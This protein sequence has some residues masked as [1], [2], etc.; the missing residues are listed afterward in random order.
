MKHIVIISGGSIEREFA[1]SFCR[2]YEFYKIIGVDGG[3][4]FL[5]ENGIRPTNIVGDFDT[6]EPDILQY[7]KEETG[8]PIRK[9]NPEKDATDT[10]IALR[11]A[12]SM[13][14]EK[15]TILGAF[16]TR[17][18]H[19]LGNMQ[20]LN[21][22]LEAGVFCSLMDAHNYVYLAD[23]DFHRTKGECFGNYFSLF[24]MAGEVTGL[25]LRGVKYPLTEYH[26]TGTDSL[27]VSNEIVEEEASVSFHK[28]RLLVIESRD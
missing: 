7:Y 6:L 4:R 21:I 28:G 25:T 3:V 9:F 17:A 14:A 5:Y 16:G 13:G 22:A 19:L 26:L 24:P 15:V 18:D 10:E 12:I 27:C 11:L 8:I 23:K 20:I 2:K 1:L